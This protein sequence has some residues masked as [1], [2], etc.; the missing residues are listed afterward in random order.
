MC[1]V[2]AVQVPFVRC[3]YSQVL[4]NSKFL[5]SQRH[6]L[7]NEMMFFFAP[8]DREPKKIVLK[9]FCSCDKIQFLA[10]I[11]YGTR[12]ILTLI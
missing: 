11:N 7:M 10:T 6:V 9:T 4:S 8:V 5:N 2:P 12:R 3:L 1:I